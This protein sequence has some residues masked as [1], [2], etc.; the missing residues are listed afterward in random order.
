MLAFGRE[1]G[2]GT[3]EGIDDDFVFD[4]S[5]QRC[6]LVERRRKELGRGLSRLARR[7]G[8]GDPFFAHG[9]HR[10]RPGGAIIRGLGELSI[11]GN[12]CPDVLAQLFPEVALGGRAD[13][14]R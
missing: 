7:L 1:N 12:D 11:G 13:R 10:L 2:D 3:G 14:R 5:R 8:L 4:V 6:G 9:S